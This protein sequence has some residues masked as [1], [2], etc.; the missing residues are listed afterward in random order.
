MAAALAVCG[1]ATAQTPGV[2]YSWN[3]PSDVDGWETEGSSNETI[4]TNTTPGVLTATEMGDALDPLIVGG[5]VVIRDGHNRRTESST[6]QGGLDLTGLD[7]LEIDIAHNHPTGTVDVQ[8]YLQ[9]TPGYN[10]IWGGSNGALGGPDWA[11]GPGQ[12]TLRFPVNLLSPAQQAYI[13]AIGLSV[14]DHAALGNLTWT[15]SELRSL[16][17]PLTQ[18]DVVTH[19][20]GT[21]DGGLHGVYANFEQAAIVG[22]DGGQNQTGFMHNPAGSGSL[23]WTDKGGDGLPGG[24]PSGAAISWGNGTLWQNSGGSVTE[25][26]SFNERLA[27]FSNYNRMTVRISA[28]DS[29][30]PAGTVG[31]QGFF[32][33]TGYAYATAAANLNLTTDGAYHELV[34]DI[35]NVTDLANVNAWGLN[36]FAHPNNI[37]FN[38]DN[39]RFSKVAGVLGDYNGN[40]SVDAADYV[41]WRNGGPLQNEGD[42]PGTV[43]QAD[44][45]FW[46]SR[47]GANSGNGSL[48]EASAT[49]PEP[50]TGLLMLSII[51]ATGICGRRGV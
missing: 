18:R 32:Q 25:G 16:G 39:I 17:T 1:T 22:N 14:R 20:T 3:G 10:Y 35:S 11:V 38:I 42:N 26:N 8:F 36:V 6:E 12:H 15:I 49:V 34:Y 50:P 27:D 9:A 19:D 21:P 46:R 51:A 33:R 5:P 37:V 41:L 44:Y 29:V 4:L 40:G 48:A 23:Q 7:F 24:T 2:L 47:F 28:L 30:N 13:R 43:N 31:I 45:D